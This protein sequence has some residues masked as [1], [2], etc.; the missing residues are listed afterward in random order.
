MQEGLSAQDIDGAG[1]D[2]KPPA[3]GD[4]I[5][6]KI[7]LVALDAAADVLGNAVAVNIAAVIGDNVEPGSQRDDA[8][9]DGDCA[10]AGD[11]AAVGMSDIAFTGVCGG[12]AGE[13]LTVIIGFAA[14]GGKH[15]AGT[16]GASGAA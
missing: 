3:L 16:V 10:D 8:W 15:A 7:D 9:I 14:G 6:I 2:T 12:G 11:G 13:Y 4:G 5:K 1:A